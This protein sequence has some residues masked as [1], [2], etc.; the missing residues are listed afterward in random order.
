VLQ[1]GRQSKQPVHFELRFDADQ[2]LLA[3]YPWEMIADENAR[4]LVRYGD[5][6]LT[7]TERWDSNAVDAMPCSHSPPRSVPA[8]LRCRMRGG[9]ACWPL[10]G[11]VTRTGELPKSWL[12][13]PVTK[14]MLRRGE[15]DV[16]LSSLD[17]DVL[18][19]SKKLFVDEHLDAP[20]AIFTVRARAVG[21][22]LLSFSV[23]QDGGEIAAITRQIE[24]IDRDRQPRATI[25][26]RSHTVP[27][28]DSV[29]QI[30]RTIGPY[31]ILEQIGRGGMAAVYKAYQKS[32]DRYVVVE[33]LQTELAQYEHFVTRFRREAWAVAMLHHPNIL[34]VY[35]F[36]MSQ[37]M[38]YIVM[39]YVDGGSLADRIA[40]GPVKIEQALSIAAQLADALDH[41]HREG[42]V[43]GDVKPSNILIGRD[44][45]PL[46]T[47]F[48][49]A[50]A[51]GGTGGLTRT[52]TT[53][54]TPEYMAPEQIQGQ[55][56]DGRTDIYALGTVLY[57]MLAGRVPFRATTPVAALYKQVNE[58][59]PPLRQAN[60]RVPGWL[61]AAVNR[62]LAKRPEERYQTAGEFAKALRERRVEQVEMPAPAAQTV[63]TRPCPMP[64]PAAPKR[65]RNTAPLVIGGILLLLLILLAIAA[66]FLL[67]GR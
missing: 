40:R 27:V 25:E 18:P 34:P 30:G 43:H 44:G 36:G 12:I 50:R 13:E 10:N 63:V 3:Q 5:C 14:R 8:V 17:C 45:R 56:V 41:A 6:T 4:F 64:A 66:Y 51:L 61:E 48:S 1:E 31:Q 19:G 2:T 46:L 11:M 16:E 23:S 26:T 24:V 33:V 67:G 22:V 65:R 37:G 39:E 29:T 52:G 57:E 15:V 28:Q 32:L 21:R 54:G 53:I 35:D 47:D 62:A 7:G 55:Q 38:C 49:I 58:P 59:P 42:V 20:P 60:F 9:S